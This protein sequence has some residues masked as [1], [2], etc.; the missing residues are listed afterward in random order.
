MAMIGTWARG[1]L[2]LAALCLGLGLCTPALAQPGRDHGR[3]NGW[4]PDRGNGHRG[5]D[6]RY[7]PP[8]NYSAPLFGFGLFGPPVVMRPHYAPPPP[9]YYPPPPR[10]YYQAPPPAYYGY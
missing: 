5:Q 9:V 6:R 8:R 1:S 7:G 3:H 10:G 4:G 2:P